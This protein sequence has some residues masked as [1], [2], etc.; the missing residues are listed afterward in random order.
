MQMVVVGG[1]SRDIGK[2]SVVC[3]IIRSLADRKWLAI[4]LTQ[5]GYGGTS[6]DAHRHDH[7]LEDHAFAIRQE[8]DRSGETDTSRF[9]LAG[10]RRALWVTAPW[11]TM[12]DAIAQLQ[13]EIERA[14]NCII[15]SNSILRFYEP[16]VYLSLLDPSTKDFKASAREFLERADAYLWLGPQLGGSPGASPGL[17]AKAHGETERP[18][19]PPIHLETSPWEGIS[20]DVLRQKPVFSI[21]PERTITSEIVEFVE[22][23][24]RNGAGARYLSS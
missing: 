22:T 12:D 13:Q 5:F 23:R 11:E 19:W 20:L 15:E 17:N 9:L 10:A 18:L 1:N 2:T 16:N 7:A 14:E 21:G 6:D 8:R 24:L 3:G 4:K